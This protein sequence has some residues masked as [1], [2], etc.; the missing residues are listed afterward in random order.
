[1]HNANFSNMQSE[2]WSETNI[3]PP[4]KHMIHILFDVGTIPTF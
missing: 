4:F 1:M 2:A 3:A